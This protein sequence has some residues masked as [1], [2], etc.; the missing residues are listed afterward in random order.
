L[1]SL[2][3]AALLSHV[4]RKVS[5]ACAGSRLLV[6]AGN[7]VHYLYNTLSLLISPVVAFLTH[8][9][10]KMCVVCAGSRLLVSV[11]N[12]VHYMYDTLR[13]LIG[14]TAA[15]T[16][17]VMSSFFI[18]A[19]FSPDGTHILSGSSDKNAYIWQA[20]SFIVIVSYSIVVFAFAFTLLCC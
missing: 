16:G 19:C 12:S 13:P 14:P 7:G 8:V 6:S 15:F 9:N 18:K 3:G 10:S 11:G 20:S 5:V 17:H 2:P 4:D 1:F